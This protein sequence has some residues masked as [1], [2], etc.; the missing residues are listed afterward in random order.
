MSEPTEYGDPLTKPFWEAATRHELVV[1]RCTSCGN[2]QFY[3]R[4]MCLECRA[5]GLE[6]VQVGGQA[7]VY[8]KTTVHLQI[9]P[10]LEPP[11]VAALVDLDEGPRLATNIVNGDAEIGDRVRLTWRDRDDAPPLPVFE[12]IA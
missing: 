4:P 9:D 11:Y 10:A 5:Q 1:Q 8:S 3:P 7:T 2:H 12:P 6:W